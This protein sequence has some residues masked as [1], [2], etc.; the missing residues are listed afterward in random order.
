M[1]NKKDDSYWQGYIQKQNEAME[2]CKQCKY[3]KK[4]NK[5]DSLVKK[6]EVKIEE[7]EKIAKKADTIP[8]TVKEERLDGTIVYS[9]RFSAEG[10]I[11]QIAMKI[12]Q[13]LLKEAEDD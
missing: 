3:R 10:Y 11:A 12:L 7:L 9:Q 2:I 4:A 1:L 13:E 5:Y 6:L 8:T